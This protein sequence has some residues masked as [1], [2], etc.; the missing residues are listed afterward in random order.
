M[1]FEA[2]FTLSLWNRVGVLGEKI[3]CCDQAL[4]KKK[5]CLPEKVEIGLV[6]QVPYKSGMPVATT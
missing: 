1:G 4:K 3:M 5:Y 2:C 6:A